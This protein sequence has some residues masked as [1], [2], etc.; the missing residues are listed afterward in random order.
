MTALIDTGFM[1]AVLAH[2]DP[3]HSAC[4]A[5]VNAEP[6][7]LF[8]SV[9]LPE[10]AYMVFRDLGREP[11]VQ[12]MRQLLDNPD[13]LIEPTHDD[14]SRATELLEKYEDSKLDFVDCVI[15]AMAER[16]NIVRI[17]TI[18]QRDFRMIRPSHIPAFEILP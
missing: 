1:L 2:N 14:L 13:K 3:H 18:D 11:F 12:F 4:R 17:L 7:A 9:V 6:D 10:L 8:P 16:L 5:V 15:T